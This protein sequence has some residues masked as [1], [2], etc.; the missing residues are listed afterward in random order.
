MKL[1]IW[2][3]AAA[4]T[5][6]SLAMVV[7]GILFQIF[8]V[9]LYGDGEPLP[10]LTHCFIRLHWWWFLLGSIPVLVAAR[11]L[12]SARALT[13]ERALAFAGACTL[14]IVFL[15]A[16]AAY[17]LLLPLLTTTFSMRHR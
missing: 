1:A 2:T 11:Y 4:V 17:S 8:F 10:L 5:V 16:I 7:L 15:F 3:Y 6:A 12:T 14:F 9:Q 13:P